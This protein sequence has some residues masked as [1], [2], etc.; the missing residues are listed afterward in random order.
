M[1]VRTEN[2]LIFFSQS[3]VAHSCCV[4]RSRILT[5]KLYSQSSPSYPALHTVL[6]V[7]SSPSLSSLPLLSL[8]PP[9]SVMSPQSSSS[10]SL[11]L[12]FSCAFLLPSVTT[13]GHPLKCFS[14]QPR[15]RRL[16]RTIG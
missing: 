8:L 7:L 13:A 11:E 15:F 14:T 2:F 16:A 10:L 5:N 9:S 12:D 6:S 3:T 1:K 4:S